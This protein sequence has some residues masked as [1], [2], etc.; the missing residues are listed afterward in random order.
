MPQGLVLAPMLF[1]LHINDLPETTT[2]KLIRADDNATSCQVSGL[3]MCKQVL[4]SDFLS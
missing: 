2:K 1:N 4:N 3:D